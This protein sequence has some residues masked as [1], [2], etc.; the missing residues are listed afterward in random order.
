MIYE[1]NSSLLINIC[2]L[3]FVKKGLCRRSCDVGHIWI[4]IGLSVV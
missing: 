2:Q 3:L 1:L 4:N